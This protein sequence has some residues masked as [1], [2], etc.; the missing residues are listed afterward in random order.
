MSSHD[1]V[2]DT[3]FEA[4]FLHPRYWLS[5]LAL[6]VLMLLACVLW[7][8]VKAGWEQRLTR[9]EHAFPALQDAIDEVFDKRIGDVSGRGKLATGYLL[10]ST[11][12]GLAAAVFG[13]W[14][15]MLQG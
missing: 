7:Q 2:F 1:P 8:D 13:A 3:R 14:L 15:A 10:L 12:A 11:V 9:G 4:R 6:G 5:W